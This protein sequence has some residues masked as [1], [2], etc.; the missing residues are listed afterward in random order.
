MSMNLH[1]SVINALYAC[2]GRW[3]EIAANAGVGYSWLCKIASG[4]IPDPRITNVEKVA[5]AMIKMDLFTAKETN[6]A[7]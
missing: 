6:H 1:R 3:P 7:A 2:K 4:A 5:N